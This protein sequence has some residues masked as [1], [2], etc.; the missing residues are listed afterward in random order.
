MT[1]ELPDL[2]VKFD[3]L[4]SILARIFLKH[5]TSAL[6]TDILAENCAGCERDGAISHGIFRIPG[7]MASLDT[8]WVD[9]K[10]KPD[11]SVISPSFIR[12]DARN[13]FA[14]PSLAA[15]ADAIDDAIKET[16]IAVV[17]TRNSHHFSALWPDV[18]PFARRG[19]M[20]ITFVNGLAN[21]VPHGGRAPVYGTNPIAFATPVAG[22][23]PLVVD[24]ATSVM[25]NGEVRLHALAN[26]S[27]P[28]GTGVDHN[29]NPS[30]DPHA[31]L[32]GG[33]LNT[34]GGYK[35]SSIALMVEL[36]AGALTG[37]QLSFENDFG[38][39]IGAQTPKAGQLL[40][41]IDPE[42]GGNSGFAERVS[43]LCDRLI[44]A[45]QERLPGARRYENRRQSSLF[46][47]PMA[48]AKLLELQ[49]FAG[50]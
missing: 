29:G 10:A 22:A 5:G 50:S 47:I 25:A 14:Q 40:I 13:G 2:H 39:C 43:V 20:A 7:Y 1:Y 46:G 28:E 21:V 48:E 44:D 33:A 27:L 26:R 49:T 35:G 9:G 36:M 19:L 17:A 30:T 3:D 6:V 12:I 15:A 34:F 32:A 8:G 24:Q 11:I 45:G 31:V 42:R 18:E 38:D 4:K 37:G 23:N 16:G 41:V